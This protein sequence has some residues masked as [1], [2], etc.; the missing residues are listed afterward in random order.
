MQVGLQLLQNEL[1]GDVARLTTHVQ[2]CLA[3]NQVVA[4]CLLSTDF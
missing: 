1:N 3:A 2:T 4:S